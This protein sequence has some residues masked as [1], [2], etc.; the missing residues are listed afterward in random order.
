MIYKAFLS[1]GLLVFV[2]F[3]CLNTVPIPLEGTLGSAVSERF[4][5]IL[6]IFRHPPAS[7]LA[8]FRIPIP[9]QQPCADWAN[10]TMSIVAKAQVVGASYNRCA[11]M[12]LAI[13]GKR[14]PGCAD[15]ELFKANVIDLV[16]RHLSVMDEVSINMKRL[17]ESVFEASKHE[18]LITK[19]ILTHLDIP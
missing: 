9:S 13:S 10:F 8:I 16:E 12:E 3:L 18:I 6:P 7:G 5:V 19:V 15:T 4:F 1:I 11:V 14:G 2:V 17:Q